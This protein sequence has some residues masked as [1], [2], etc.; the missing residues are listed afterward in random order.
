MLRFQQVGRVDPQH[1][2]R[3]CGACSQRA[4]GPIGVVGTSG[5]V[6]SWH[7]LRPGTPQHAQPRQLQL[8][9]AVPESRFS[10]PCPHLAANLRHVVTYRLLLPSEPSPP[11]LLACEPTAPPHFLVAQNPRHVVMKRVLGMEGDTGAPPHTPPNCCR[12]GCRRSCHPTA[13]AAPAAQLLLLPLLWVLAQYCLVDMRT[14]ST[15]AAAHVLPLHQSPWLPSIYPFVSHVQ[16]TSRQ[17]PS[18]GWAGR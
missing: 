10:L 6:W 16:C 4:G 13:A 5:V 8:T 1:P 17:L 3:Q 15:A 12:H 2:D 9:L 11:P 18:S 7:R 14:S